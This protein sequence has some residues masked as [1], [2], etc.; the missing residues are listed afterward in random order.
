[1]NVHLQQFDTPWHGLVDG[2]PVVADRGEHSR[3]GQQADEEWKKW[4]VDLLYKLYRILDYL[5]IQRNKKVKAQPRP[6]YS[7]ELVNCLKSYITC[8]K[9]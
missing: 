2:H 3:A 7:S 6:F 8:S 4:T 1:M 9:K 5:L